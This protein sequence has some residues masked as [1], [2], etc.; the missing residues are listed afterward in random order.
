M[1]EI[2]KNAKKFEKMWKIPLTL[3]I[4]GVILLLSIENCGSIEVR[5]AS[6]LPLI[7]DGNP[8]EGKGMPPKCP[9]S[10]GSGCWAV[11]EYP[12]DCHISWSAIILCVLDNCLLP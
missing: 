2:Y 11:G 8:A 1:S 9:G 6:V 12:P 7:R 5:Y 3:P 10:P 4:S